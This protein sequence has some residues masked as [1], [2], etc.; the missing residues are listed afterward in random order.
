M[1]MENSTNERITKTHEHPY[2]KHDIL[3]A[4]K[5]EASIPTGTISLIYQSL[6]NI[7]IILSRYSIT[8]TTVHPCNMSDT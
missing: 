8:Y 5:Q 2:N 4:I 7:R 1:P 3:S 6:Q